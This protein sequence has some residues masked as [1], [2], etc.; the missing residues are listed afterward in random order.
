[1]KAIEIERWM[2]REISR[3][4]GTKHEE[5]DVDAPFADHGLD[6]VAALQMT[7]ELETMLKRPLEA[8][9]VFEYPTIATLARY[10]ES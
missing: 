4:L 5:I 10:L 1:M 2:V 8:T 7:G 9:L 3:A 6:S